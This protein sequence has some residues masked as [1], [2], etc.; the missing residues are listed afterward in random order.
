VV[1]S[2]EYAMTAIT[3]GLSALLYMCAS[4]KVNRSQVINY[5]IYDNT[6]DRSRFTSTFPNEK[7]YATD[8]AN[9]LGYD[10]RFHG[11]YLWYCPPIY[12]RSATSPI[13]Y[14]PPDIEVGRLNQV[15]NSALFFLGGVLA[16]TEVEVFPEGASCF[17]A[18][19]SLGEKPNAWVKQIRPR[20]AA[21]K[22]KFTNRRYVITKSWLLTDRFGK[23]RT[24][25]GNSFAVEAFDE[26]YFYS[27][28]KTTS[29]FFADKYKGLDFS[30]FTSKVLFHPLVESLSEANY[31]LWFESMDEIIGDD[32]LLVKAKPRMS[33]ARIPNA[34][35]RF[36]FV[37]VPN[38]YTK[39]PA[40]LILEQLP[41]SRYFGY[42]SSIM[43]GFREE[44]TSLF[45]PPDASLQ[46]I[47]DD[48]YAGL[49]AVLGI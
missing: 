22:S 47:F 19:S 32:I 1:I 11:P 25:I 10:I 46:K 8:I 14:T 44:L 28:L 7:L 41:N 43:L 26:R 13:R 23:V 45:P 35:K 39:L 16:G 9:S 30:H 38:E 29:L 3:T 48:T 36:R 42:Y 33:E 4:G 27:S 5:L 40:E 34:V 20:L 37:D 17:S 6:Y 31:E 18:F 21:I 24:S 49:K 15:S 2:Y 12:E